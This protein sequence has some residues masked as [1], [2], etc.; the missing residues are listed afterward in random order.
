MEGVNHLM[1]VVHVMQLFTGDQIADD[2]AIVEGDG[3]A[4]PSQR[5]P[6]VISIPY[7]KQSQEYKLISI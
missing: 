1:S 7:W 2:A 5:V 6:H 4:T 3:H